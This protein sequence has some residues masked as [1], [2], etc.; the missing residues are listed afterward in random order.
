[1]KKGDLL[2]EFGSRDKELS[3]ALAQATLKQAEA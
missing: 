2:F 1:V 3:V